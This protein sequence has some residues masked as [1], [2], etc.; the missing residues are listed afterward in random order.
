MKSILH[1]SERIKPIYKGNGSG[2]VHPVI[3]R[4]AHGEAFGLRPT[5]ADVLP[6]QES[7]DTE[8]AGRPYD[9]EE[10]ADDVLGHR[11]QPDYLPEPEQTLFS[12]SHLRRM[13][14]AERPLVGHGLSNGHITPHQAESTKNEDT[15][16]KTPSMS[17]ALGGSCVRIKGPPVHGTP[18]ERPPSYRGEITKFSRKSQQRMRRAVAEADE[19]QCGS[20][21]FVTL[22]Y[23]GFYT[24]CRSTWMQH[25]DALDK[26]IRRAFP[27]FIFN[28]WKLEPQKR[29]APHFHLLLCMQHECTKETLRELRIFIAKAWYEIVDSNQPAHLVV[30]TGVEAAKS[31]HGVR[32]YIS[33]YISKTIEGETIPSWWPPGRFWG[34]RGTIPTEIHTIQLDLKQFYAVRR[35]AFRYLKAVTRGST[36]RPTIGSPE[37][38]VVIHW[39][40]NTAMQVLAYLST[41]AYDVPD[42]RSHRANQPPPYA[43][44]DQPLQH[45]RV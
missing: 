5:H 10:P 16:P 25:L 26:R 28:M 3:S 23:P 27:E 18:P 34:V 11:V 36:F 20:P 22:T 9:R 38:G 30:G 40:E 2:L 29:G 6:V 14:G 8:A 41:I 43:V 15:E 44:D 7:P 45:L 37:S 21:Y 1:N 4:P 13:S 39:S 12:T 42:D 24:S 35:L 33:K 19:S 31:W 17:V 32:H